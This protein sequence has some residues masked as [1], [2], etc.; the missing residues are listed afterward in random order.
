[1]LSDH[2]LLQRLEYDPQDLDPADWQV[3]TFLPFRM[4]CNPEF[5]VGEAVPIQ[6]IDSSVEVV[7]AIPVLFEE[8]R[9]VGCKLTIEFNELLWPGLGPVLEAAGLTLAER[10]ALLACTSQTFRQEIN[11]RVEMR[12]LGQAD[13]RDEFDAYQSV[14]AAGRGEG[15]DTLSEE[16]LAISDKRSARMVPAVQ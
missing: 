6:P 7:A 5:G 15:D 1:M 4:A 3:S 10:E 12:F 14:V 9:K 8:A 11:P 2:Q 13:S 16:E